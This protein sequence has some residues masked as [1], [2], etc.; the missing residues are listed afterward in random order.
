MT[1]VKD[2]NGEKILIKIGDGGSPETFT[3]DCLINTERGIDFSGDVN[4]G[5]VP[6]CDDP[7]AP[8]WK[9]A[10]VD[11]LSATINGAG[12]LHSASVESFF[13]W[14]SSGASKNVQA[15]IDVLAADGGGYWSGAFVLTSFSITGPRKD[16]ATCSITLVSDGALTWTDAA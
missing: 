4:Q 15:W 12:T 1:A 14:F 10:I 7:S 9:Y 8:G 3:H 5:V 2:L 16:K 6:D 13:N 11:G